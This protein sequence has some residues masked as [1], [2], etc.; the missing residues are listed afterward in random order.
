M[1]F[2]VGRGGWGL[3]DLNCHFKLYQTSTTPSCSEP[4]P[5]QK[6]LA[7]SVLGVVFPTQWIF[8]IL[9]VLVEKKHTKLIYHMLWLYQY[10]PVPFQRSHEKNIEH[11]ERLPHLDHGGPEMTFIYFH[12][13]DWVGGWIGDWTDGWVDGW[14]DEWIDGWVGGWMTGLVAGLVAGLMDGLMDDFMDGWID[15]W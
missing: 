7:N 8:I 14:V 12:H 13:N 11:F 4:I 15:G 9:I 10:P 6:S 2:G 1:A 3:E 5:A